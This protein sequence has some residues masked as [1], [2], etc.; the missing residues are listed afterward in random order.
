[1]AGGAGAKAGSGPFGNPDHDWD[2]Y[3]KCVIGGILSCGLTHT[4][5]VPLDVV[6]CRMQVRARVRA[7][8]VRPRRDR[9][10]ACMR[11]AHRSAG[12]GVME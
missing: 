4:A 2:Y 7:R 8:A 3:G 11:A 5:V 12:C 6:K 10:W 1:M 9:A